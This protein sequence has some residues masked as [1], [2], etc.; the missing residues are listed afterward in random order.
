MTKKRILVI[1]FSILLIIG[2]P[3][4]VYL[5]LQQQNLQQ[6]AATGADLTI[7]AFQL[8]DAGGNVRTTFAPGEDIYVKITVKN[9]G[10]AKGVSNDGHTYT[11][12]YSNAS[13][14]V[15]AG[16]ASDVNLE[17]RN[18]EFGAGAEKTYAS[19]YV[20]VNNSYFDKKVSWH[21]NAPGTYTAR[22]YVNY[23]NFV[24]ELDTTNNQLAIA[25]T[26]SDTRYV[27]GTTSSSAP[28]GFSSLTCVANENN[29]EPNLTACVTDGSSGG[30]AFAKV[31]NKST[32]QTFQ[33]GLASYQA[34]LPYP[35]PYPSCEPADCPSSYGWI[36][37]QTIHSAV[38]YSLAP[39]K[40]VYLSVAAPTCAWQT[41]VFTGNII[42]SFRL[43]D[44]WYSGQKT[45]LDGWYETKLG[46]CTPVAPTPTPLATPTPTPTLPPGVTP[47][48]TNTPTPT[49][50]PVPSETPSPTPSICPTPGAVTNVKI[51]CPNC[52]LTPTPTI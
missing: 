30:K 3:V 50:T 45:Y 52:N 21:R 38:T 37:T 43:P 17:L 19:T 33:V 7:S 9:Q 44:I 35:T 24:T 28:S 31:T 29:V 46:V 6:H 36:W 11:E 16:K 5:A 26:I 12:V 4:G 13:S 20:G 8:T 48:P 34:Y 23:N 32:T 1:I 27:K 15:S 42:P 41:D 10:S 49:E 40:T 18:G 14:T 47:T 22:V 2:L 51:V 39:G 25:Y